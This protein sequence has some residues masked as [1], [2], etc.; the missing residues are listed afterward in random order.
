MLHL[1]TVL[2]FPWDNIFKEI[3]RWQENAAL[4]LHRQR[5]EPC[6]TL[7]IKWRTLEEV[8]LC[9]PC[10]WEA[11]HYGWFMLWMG[12]TRPSWAKW[13]T[14]SYT[15]KAG[16]KRRASNSKSSFCGGRKREAGWIGKSKDFSP[17][18]SKVEL[19]W[20]SENRPCRKEWVPRKLTQRSWRGNW[21]G[22]DYGQAPLGSL[23]CRWHLRHRHSGQQRKTK[24]QVAL[25]SH[26]PDFKSVFS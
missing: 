17:C 3:W 7:C 24:E 13:L 12:N 9:A 5:E 11:P 10:R 25:E 20:E 4:G 1:I 6:L 18:G 22:T 21:Q 8:G 19:T 26:K 23:T 15:V 2:L 14:W 16:L